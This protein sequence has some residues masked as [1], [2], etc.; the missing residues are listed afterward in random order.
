M[1]RVIL[2]RF[3]ESKWKVQLLCS[4]STCLLVHMF[5][6]ELRERERVLRSCCKRASLS[7][8]DL[9]NSR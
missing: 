8:E 7:G 6:G 4:V 3:E 9:E 5:K 2:G 1:R